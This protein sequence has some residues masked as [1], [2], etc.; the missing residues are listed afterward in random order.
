MN[1]FYTAT[2]SSK[3][4]VQSFRSIVRMRLENFLFF[5]EL[6]LGGTIV[7]YYHFVIYFLSI[8]AAIISFIL[9]AIY[10]KLKIELMFHLLQVFLLSGRHKFDLSRLGRHC[11]HNLPLLSDLHF[12]GADL[13]S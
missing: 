12:M 1:H 9:A 11:Q 6:E 13:G 8:L 7:G 2:L 3:T 4:A 5:F 10:C